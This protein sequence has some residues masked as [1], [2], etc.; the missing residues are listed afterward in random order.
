MSIRLQAALVASLSLAACAH[1]PSSRER[2]SA[3]LQHALGME[4]LRAGRAADAIKL[5]DAAIALD[6]RFA[7]P[8]LGKGV[9]LERAFNRDEEAERAY[10]RALELNPGFPEAWNNLGQL[11][12]RTGRTEEALHA[13][14]AAVSEMGY[15]EPW[16]ARMNKGLTLYG[17]SRR[18][19]GLAEMR[20][21]LR[22]APAYC[23]GHRQLGL[24][25]LGEAKVKESVE[26]FRTYAR[27][28]DKVPDAHR[29]LGSAHM[30][31]GDVESARAAFQ[32]CADLG[33]GTTDGEEC[34]RSLELIQ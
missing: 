24:I 32:R 18:E 22:A 6:G 13:F 29:Q 15:R 23:A 5:F 26:E 10:R 12:A 28:C 30:K 14:D 25:L 33:V 7:D 16:V 34:R 1:G 20:A 4:A 3:E 17:A 2:Q 27:Y 11:L 9:L 19:E 21:C 31:G 8:W